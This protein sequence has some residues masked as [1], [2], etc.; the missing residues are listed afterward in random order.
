MSYT[1]Y[2][3]SL[4]RTG[5]RPY[6]RTDPQAAAAGLSG[7]SMPKGPFGP[8]RLSGMGQHQPFTP[9]GGFKLHGLG[10]LGDAPIP[11][12]SLLTYSGTWQ[13]VFNTGAGYA[14]PTDPQS[15]LNAVVNAINADG[16]LTV[17]QA[18][19]TL[20]SSFL[21]T[22]EGIFGS[23][24]SFPVTLVLQVTNGQGFASVNDVISIIHHYVYTVLG[25]LVPLSSINGSITQ[26][27]TPAGAV[28]SN[29]PNYQAAGLLNPGGFALPAGTPSLAPPGSPQTFTQWLAA[30][31]SLLA[32]AGLGVAAILIMRR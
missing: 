4:Y 19:N 15:I 6:G 18:P 29:A 32:I 5:F 27:N 7:V 30:N 10:A 17:T 9:A 31:G 20:S 25:G 13:S 28:S 24:N 11:N 12:G 22:I 2:D 26:V 8:W 3:K 1:L 14:Q 23:S 16:Q 21:A